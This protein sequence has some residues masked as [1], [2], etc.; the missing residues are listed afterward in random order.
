M[1]ATFSVNVTL[2]TLFLLLPSASLQAQQCSTR[3][4][5]GRYLVRCD[6]YLTPGPNAC[7][8]R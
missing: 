8:L 7:Q 1:K 5:S 6:G 2:F 3:T 4:T